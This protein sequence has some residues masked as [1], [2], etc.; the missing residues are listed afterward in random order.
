MNKIILALNS[1][2]F[3]TVVVMVGLV[4]TNPTYHLFSQSVLD[5][6]TSILGILAAYFHVNP[7][8][9]YQKP[10]TGN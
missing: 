6:A 9:N 1:R 4:L 3:W 10:T 8:Q 7:S 2:T 5:I